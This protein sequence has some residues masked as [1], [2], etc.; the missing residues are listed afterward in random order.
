MKIGY[1]LDGSTSYY[2]E[3]YAG[4]AQNCLQI[5]KLREPSANGLT[6]HSE[7]KACYAVFRATKFEKSSYSTTQSCIIGSKPQILFFELCNDCFM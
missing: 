4:S 6:W 1:R 5:V 3:G 7:S 2:L